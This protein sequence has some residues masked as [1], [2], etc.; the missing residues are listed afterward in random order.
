MDDVPAKLKTA[1]IVQLVVGLVDLTVGWVLVTT[2]WGC[3]GG[4]CLTLTMGLCPVGYCSWALGFLI[5]PVGIL[6]VAGGIL[7]LT[8]PKSAGTIMKI[9]SFVGMGALLAGS[10]TSAVGG[11][12]AFL[13][14]GDP[15]VR[16]YLEG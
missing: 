5:I 2:L 10:I 16:A 3:F 12:V 4:A 11:I 14:L 9:A 15:D 13:Q 6:E 1:A 8:N 7:G